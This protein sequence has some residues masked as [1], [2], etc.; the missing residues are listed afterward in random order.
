ME[1]LS[2]YASASNNAQLQLSSFVSLDAD[3]EMAQLILE[4]RTTV[5]MWQ[6]IISDALTD[7]LAI[8][9][10]CRNSRTCGARSRAWRPRSPARRPARRP[11]G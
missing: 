2:N 3:D 8:T 7:L 4:V 11:R 10:N 9:P 5:S 6:W 1:H